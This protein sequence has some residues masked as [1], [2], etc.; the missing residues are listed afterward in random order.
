MTERRITDFD[1]S[2][3][4]AILQ[5]LLLKWLLIPVGIAIVAFS[6]QRSVALIGLDLHHDTLMFGAARQL[7]NGEIPYKDFFY[8]YNLGTVVLHAQA[9]KAL[10]VKIATLK[11][12]TAIAYA[13]IA[14]LIYVCSATR[15]SAWAL[16]A[17]LVWSALSPF[18]MPAMNGYHAWSTVYMMAAV[19]TGGLCLSIAITRRPMLWAVL[20]GACFNLAFWFKQVAAVQVLVILVW[21]AYNSLRSSL[22]LDTST[23]FRRIFYGLALGGGSSSVPFFIY[24]FNNGIFENWWNSAFVFNGYFAASGNSAQGFFELIRTFFPV[25]RELGYLSI[26]WALLPLCLIAIV[27]QR[28]SEGG[29]HLLTS[30]DDRNFVA[31]IFA[32]LSIAGWIEYFPLA[33]SFHTQIFMAPM[34]VLLALHL[35][36]IKWKSEISNKTGWPLIGLLL[37]TISTLVYQAQKHIRGLREKVTA[38]YEVIGGEFPT[39]KLRL[40]AEYADSLRRFNEK[41]I[42]VLG[43][44]TNS[45]LIPMSADPLRAMIPMGNSTSNDF[46]MGLNWTFPNEIIEPGFNKRIANSIANRKS[47]LYAD[48][49]IGIPGYVPVALLEMP[50]PLTKSHTLYVPSADYQILEPPTF[51]INDQVIKFNSESFSNFIYSDADIE[52]YSFIKIPNLVGIRSDDIDQLHVSIVEYKDIPNHLTKFQYELYLKAVPG[53]L[54]EKVAGLYERK[55]NTRY[56]LRLPL[57]QEQT[58]DI[59]KF[60]LSQGK[61]FDAQDR[62]VFFTTLSSKLEKRPFLALKLANEEH[63]RVFYK[64]PSIKLNNFLKAKVNEEE[65]LLAVPCDIQ[66]NQELILY[67]QIVMKNNTTN[68]FYVHIIH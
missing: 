57:E 19:M 18:Y 55:Q 1:L 15:N 32:I 68:N 59:A 46:K 47:P 8:Q 56:E 39:S 33:H 61:L 50:S 14:V 10:G 25:N 60:L 35:E 31:S 16:A 9:L 30:K 2:V 23:R 48:S 64:K 6:M 43:S 28:Q 24:I 49:L 36:Q 65:F 5:G 21:V 67:V 41:L 45:Q 54:A 11:I 51:V 40:K 29:D 13:S 53:E 34:F 58:L 12:I 20:A 62:P 7:L 26:V 63:L 4:T 17:A 27:T 42:A 52:D 37:L 38:P 66:P 22:S 3:L 44:A